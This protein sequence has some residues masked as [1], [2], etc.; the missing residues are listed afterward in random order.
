MYNVI[1]ADDEKTA[2]ELLLNLIQKREPDLQVIAETENGS[3]ALEAISS[4]HPDILITDICMPGINGLQLCQEAHNLDPD[5]QMILLSG[6][7]R[8][9][10]AQEAIH[11]GVSEYLLKPITPKKF[12]LAVQRAVTRLDNARLQKRNHLIKNL[13]SGKITSAADLHEIFAFSRYYLVFIRQNGL[14]SRFHTDSMH[15]VY[16]EI[17]EDV[18]FY[19][20]DESEAFIFIPEK[21]LSPKRFPSTIQHLQNKY[22]RQSDSYITAVYS[23][24]ACATCEIPSLMNQIYQVER[25]LSTP[26]ESQSVDIANT[27]PLPRT[28]LN[29]DEIQHLE[30]R[31]IPLLNRANHAATLDTILGFFQSWKGEHH[32]QLWLEHADQIILDLITKYGVD[33]VDCTVYDRQLVQDL[34]ENATSLDI[35]ANNL[36][37]L[38]REILTSA[39][40]E[41]NITSRNSFSLVTTYLRNHLQDHITIQDLCDHFSVSQASLSRM[42]RKHEGASFVQVLTKLRMEEATKIIQETPSTL[43]KDVAAMVG[44]DDQFYFSR[45]FR[46][47]FG[48]SPSTYAEE[49]LAN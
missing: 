8:F 19:G 31:L 43:I 45:V 21:I 40:T 18:I 49:V 14:L 17:E 44:F 13:P 4:T 30:N 25:E 29:R 20:R 23:S 32:S 38:Y 6:Y 46:T 5:M 39:Q 42:F 47:Y 9:E 33:E 35:L 41:F 3:K 36:L 24:V 22:F 2:R 26:G 10:Y 1:V 48:K 37:Q 12:H 15:E 28:R 11:I 27:H 34:F 7:Q 16:S